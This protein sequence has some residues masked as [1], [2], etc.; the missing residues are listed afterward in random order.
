MFRRLSTGHF[1]PPPS[2]A[3]MAEAYSFKSIPLVGCILRC[4]AGI[5]RAP[6]DNAHAISCR[7]QLSFPVSPTLKN[8][9]ADLSEMTTELH[10]QAR[11]ATQ[12]LAGLHHGY[13]SVVHGVSALL[14]PSL[15]PPP[16]LP[17][18]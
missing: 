8:S 4:R 5:E 14:P 16:S 10:F 6:E 3:M 18:H 7:R 1:D 12:L 15:A 9:T 2:M 13:P 11:I 17:F